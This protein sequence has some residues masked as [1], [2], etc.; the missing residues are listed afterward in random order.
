MFSKL[1]SIAR[2]LSFILILNILVFD[3]GIKPKEAKATINPLVS[4]DYEFKIV[5]NRIAFDFTNSLGEGDL[6]ESVVLK[7]GGNNINVVAHDAAKKIWKTDELFDKVQYELNITLKSGG[8][9]RKLISTFFYEDYEIDFD[10]VPRLSGNDI[11]ITGLSKWADK[12]LDDDEVLISIV[13]TNGAEQ[14]PAVTKKIK[15]CKQDVVLPQGKTKILLGK[16]SYLI[17]AKLKASGTEFNR[18]FVA[19]FHGDEGRNMNSKINSIKR[20]GNNNND[21]SVDVSLY[22][23]VASSSTMYLDEGNTTV[24]IATRQNDKLFKFDGGRQSSIINIGKKYIVREADRIRE[25]YLGIYELDKLN[26]GKFNGELTLGS[27]QGTALKVRLDNQMRDLFSKT[28]D[29]NKYIVYEIN[30]SFGKTKIGERTKVQS[31]LKDNIVSLNK[32]IE[33]GKNYF[34]EFTNGTRSYGKSFI[35]HPIDSTVSEIKETSA[36]VNWNYPSGYAPASGDRVEIYLRDRDTSNLFP[37]TPKLTLAHGSNSV[38]LTKTNSTVVTGIAPNTNYEAKIVLYNQRGM[39]TSFVNFTTAYFGLKDFIQV[40]KCFYRDAYYREAWPRNREFV[41][42]WDFDPGNIQFY[43]GDKVEIFVKPNGSGAFSGY[44]KTDLYKNPVFYAGS[45][46]NDVK[47]AVISVPGWERNYHVDLIYTIGGKQILT[48]R[49]DDEEG[50]NAYNRRTVNPR[51]GQ[52]YLDVT[53]IKQTSAKVV[54]QLDTGNEN[55]EFASY[56]PENGHLVKLHVEK[57]PSMSDNKTNFYS[58]PIFL[59]VYGKNWDYSADQQVVLNNLEPDQCYRARLQHLVEFPE[60]FEGAKY[61]GATA[62]FNFRTSAFTVK[63]LKTKVE[64]NDA[65]KVKLTWNT[66]GDVTFGEGDKLEVFLKESNSSEYPE[67][68]VQG[69]TLDPSTSKEAIIEVPKFNTLYNAKVEYTLSGKKFN[70]FVL[71]QADA[72]LGVEVTDINTTNIRDD[73]NNWK[74]KIKWTYP[75]GYQKE[76]RTNDKVKLTVTKKNDIS[77]GSLPNGEEI[78]VT[79]TEKELTGLEAN[80]DYDVKLSFLNGGTE[81]YTVSTS[82]KATNDLQIIGLNATNVKTKTATLTWSFTPSDKEFKAN[83]KVEVYIKNAPISK[84]NDDLTDFNKIYTKTHNAS[85][86]SGGDDVALFS[87]DQQ[88]SKHVETTGDLKTFKTLNLQQLGVNKEFVVKVKYT[89]N[90]A[91]VISEIEPQSNPKTSEAEIN[92][93]TKVDSLKATVFVSDQT[94]ATFGWEY[95]P[96]YELKAGDKIDIY[97]K[98]VTEGSTRDNDSGVGTEYGNPMLTL[99]HAEEEKPEQ[100]NYDMNEVTRVDISGLT[101]ERKYKSKIQFTMGTGNDSYAIS[102]EVDISTKAFEIKTFTMEDYFEYDILTAWTV[103][104]QNMKFGY[105]DT[106]EIF[107]ARKDDEYPSDPSYKLT[108]VASPNDEDEKTIDNTFSD[109]ILAE[110]LGVPQ[111]MKLV[112]TV[113]G[114]KYEKELEFTNAINP[115]KASALSVEQTKALVQI[116]LPD[117]YEF[118]QGDRLKIFAKDE[119]AGDGDL[120]TDDYLVFDEPQTE[121][122]NIADMTLIELGYLLPEA[123]YEVAV[124][125]DLEDGVVEPAKFEFTTTGVELSEVSLQSIKFDSSVVSW[126]YGDKDLDFFKD[127]EDYNYSDK[128]IIATKESDGSPINP[129]IDTVKGLN[130]QEYLGEEIKNVKD[131]SIKVEDP[132]KDYEGIIFYDIGGLVYSKN[133]KISHLTSS[134]DESTIE[135]DKATFKWKYPSNLKIG[136]SDKTEVYVRKTSESEYPSSPSFEGTG[137]GT[138]TCVLEGLEGGTEYTAKVQIIKEGII[139]DPVEAQF[140]T[141]ASVEPE[142]VI[143]NLEYE[144]VGT[145]AEFSIPNAEQLNINKEGKIGLRMGDEPYQGFSIEFNELGTGF[146]IKPTIPNKKY[147][148]IEVEIPLADG[149]TYKMT[150]KEFTTQPENITQDWLSNSY[151]FALERFPDEEGY[152]YWYKRMLDKKLN[153]EYFLKNLMFAEDEFTNRNLQDRELIAALY[154]IVVNREY[155]EEGLNFWVEI[156]KENLQNAEGQKKLA[157]E[158]LVDRMVHEPEF[159]KLCTSA[160]IFWTQAEQD[161]AGVPS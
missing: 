135:G 14:V 36:K 93:K 23:R 97:V 140:T 16:R 50:E 19:E 53:D 85:A 47:R 22:Y 128:L 159:G 95:P 59:N 33:V 69:L 86:R 118:V 60:D 92:L 62:Y 10:P 4:I 68:P 101:P 94:T 42:T 31:L 17:R 130:N 76:S 21:V 108:K 51:V 41:I 7:K 107:V 111:K 161:A 103:E 2:I 20:K 126:N 74:A 6:I 125:L 32:N 45:N 82:F 141:K 39:T 70:Q 29:S 55:G 44:P 48:S 40:E 54:W 119:F 144:V 151:K 137:T 58:E 28:G 99:T 139:I 9:T 138:Q 49:R 66:E 15:E 89:M 123:R 43:E 146:S 155:D 147:Q 114:K 106:L 75:T 145:L 78:S 149:S 152:E 96:E 37:A 26:Y 84:A 56:K 102:T 127:E 83:D 24:S 80:K 81:V 67:T 160:G 3:F 148:N 112:Y 142:I 100:N 116:E 72:E 63:D 109:Y 136:D 18:M 120:M 61:A 117:N 87:D 105:A 154:Q 91:N 132:S 150:I 110:S 65:A 8:K 104:P 35:Y 129:D 88:H 52:C 46:L 5:D 133:F 1:K 113:G 25:D 12:Y 143:D 98:E 30:D 134:V 71:V 90:D 57:V 157:Q 77:R 64:D 73:G 131:T 13:G 153:G 122:Q 79:T 27:E 34:I 124:A 121:L 156:Y 11:K 38:D 158:V 115:I